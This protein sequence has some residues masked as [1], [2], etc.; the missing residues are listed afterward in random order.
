M[1]PSHVRV[2]HSNSSDDTVGTNASLAAATIGRSHF[3]Q[4][5]LVLLFVHINFTE[6]FRL[7]FEVG[8]WIDGA[9]WL[10]R[11][12]SG[13]M[14]LRESWWRKSHREILS[15]ILW[16]FPCD[17]HERRRIAGLWWLARGLRM[18]SC[19]QRATKFRRSAS[20]SN[21]DFVSCT[22]GLKL[23]HDGTTSALSTIKFQ[24]SDSV[25]IQILSPARLASNQ[26]TTK[27]YLSPHWV[28]LLGRNS[29]VTSIDDLIAEA[30]A[31]S[32]YSVLYTRCVAASAI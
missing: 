9:E 14:R 13:S 12:I 4:H 5:S 20:V 25:Q 21:S 2:G 17:I 7:F 31:H 8:V 22:V 24:K 27:L 3:S 32:V 30:A 1:Y 16:F 10:R 6:Q 28:S 18:K 11:L 26:H 19:T 23:E 29:L 15:P